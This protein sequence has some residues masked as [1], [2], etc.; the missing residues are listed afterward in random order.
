MLCSIPYFQDLNPEHKDGIA[1]FLTAAYV[2]PQ[3]PMMLGTLRFANRVPLTVRIVS[4]LAIQAVVM[5]FM[6]LIAEANMWFMLSAIF[7]IGL[8]TA[9]LQSAVFGL[10]RFVT[11]IVRVHR[12]RR[13]MCMI[14]VGLHLIV[15]DAMV[16]HV[17]AHL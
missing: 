11:C 7:V 17:P 12:K 15:C 9:V 6:P 10:T 13:P 3:L 8:T 16:Q 5:A 4:M 2:F 14:C 1:F